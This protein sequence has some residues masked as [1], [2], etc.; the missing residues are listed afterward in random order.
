MST[1]WRSCEAVWREKGRE[2]QMQYL[3]DSRLDCLHLSLCLIFLWKEFQGVKESG[4]VV[5]LVWSSSLECFPAGQHWI[6]PEMSRVIRS[7]L[8]KWPRSVLCE[9]RCGGSGARRSHWLPALETAV[10]LCRGRSGHTK[11]K[12]HG[13][14]PR[15]TDT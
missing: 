12:P 3:T 4:M 5:V 15:H 13:S 2:G 10:R 6:K 9:K 1:T 14:T 11:A 7:T 8:P